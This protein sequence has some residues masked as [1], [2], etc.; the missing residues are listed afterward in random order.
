MIFIKLTRTVGHRFFATA[1]LLILQPL[2]ARAQDHRDWSC[3]L[4]IYEVN[5]RHYTPQGTFNAFQEHLDRLQ[6]MGAGILWMMPIHPI[7]L[8][9]RLGTLGSYYSVRDYLDVNPEFGT[10]D[11]FR[12]LVRDI[13]DRVM[14]VILDWVAN[15]TSWDNHLT[16][17]HPEWYVRDGLG[18]FIPPPGTNWSDVIELDFSKQGLRNYMIDAMKFWALEM[19]VDGFRCD[20][21]EFVPVD[22]W[23]E[24]IAAL[25]AA[26][27]GLFFLAE[28]DGPQWHQ[29]GF[30]ATYGWGLYGFG[31]GILKQ[32]ADGAVN[33]AGL[34]SYAA[35]EKSRFPPDAYRM[36]FTSNH[37]ENSW[38]GTAGEL[39]GD[40]AECF[41]VLTATLGG[42]PLIY[43]GQEAG[44]DKRLRF[45]DKDTIEWADH[46][47]ADLYTKLL[48]LRKENQALWN[49]DRGGPLQRVLTSDNAAVYAFMRE[50]N[51]DRI[52]EVLN[53]SDE[54]SDITLKGTSFAGIYRNTF[55]G[56]TMVLNGGD[57]LTLEAWGYRVYE[58]I[59][60]SAAGCAPASPCSFHLMQNHPNPFNSFTKIP[61][62]LCASE[63]IKLSLFDLTGR[64]LRVLDSGAKKPGSYAVGLDATGLSSGVYLYRLQAGKQTDTKRLLLLR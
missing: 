44:L 51:G 40:A 42:M 20:A 23:E 64:K 6:E 37:D 39:F 33:A 43:S 56:D 22:F 50:K 2:S 30:D 10:L 45:F 24:A 18:N 11:D 8:Q 1:I 54:E 60:S 32:L 47:N 52:F 53:L 49:G 15:H 62:S 38:Y 27:P 57:S 17:D 29:A 59:E 4:G 34:S 25:K 19:N 3:N 63:A 41:A 12:I 55:S 61:Y 58:V 26:K 46:A 35:S 13:H 9:N 36:Y 48:D 14:F 16:A 7:G 31:S 21:V 5:V 28:G